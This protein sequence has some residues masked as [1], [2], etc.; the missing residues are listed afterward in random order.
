MKKHSLILG[1][2]KSGQSVA[3]HLSRLGQPFAAADTRNDAALLAEWQALYPEISLTMGTLP[4]SVLNN[5]EQIIVSPGIA[6][7]IPLIISAHTK[8]IPVRGDIDLALH[9][10][11]LPVVLITGSN[12]KSTVTALVGELLNA[13]GVPAAV[14]GNFGT[15]ALD[16]LTTDA[17]ALVLEVSSF[18]L[19]ST[20][21][22]DLSPVHVPVAATVLN[23]SQDHLDRHG[24]LAHY[25]D[26]K[27]TALHQARRAVLNRDD[28]MVVAM[29]GRASSE[30]IWFGT[31]TPTHPGD[32][33]LKT[34]S[35]ESWLVLADSH[36]SVHQIIPVHEL[37]LVGWHNHMNVL[38]A[39]ALVQAVV[40]GIEL[41]DG[42]LVSVLRHF[43]GLPHRAQTVGMVG[44]V[45]YIDDSKATNVGAAVAA[46]VGM[47]PPLILIAGGQGKGQDF[48]PLA[49]ALV[50]R[51]VGV[52]LLGQ[53]QAVIAEA[54]QQQP[55]AAWPE[56]RVGSMVEAVQAAAELAPSPCTVLLAPA[57]ASLDMF[58]SY[59]D[60]GQQFAAAVAALSA[61][62]TN[63]A[64]VTS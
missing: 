17:Q 51:C 63:G 60:R 3:R 7:D 50:G 11:E 37:G 22:S 38:A 48:T 9:A 36:A 52:I 33:G 55:G 5:V 53:D 26:I 45:R 20:D 43:S 58:S 6:L 18:Q 2:G 8:G 16:L 49:E 31:D 23:I 32:F 35:G 24:S 1:M 12:G 34:I 30:V 59:M 46:I 39:L 61:K 13:V 19:E 14:G 54:L 57:C 64:E 41:N 42:R 27:E 28:S 40:P 10:T 62:Q 21:F 56:R 44:G 47:A 29:A 4:E 15:P 25:A